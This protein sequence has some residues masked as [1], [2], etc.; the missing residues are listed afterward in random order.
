VLSNVFKNKFQLQIA[1]T[2]YIIYFNYD[3]ITVFT[4]SEVP[5]KTH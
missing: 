1:I 3:F 5:N 2:H 4:A